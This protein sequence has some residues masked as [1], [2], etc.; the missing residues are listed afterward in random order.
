M[1]ANVASVETVRDIVLIV[2]K[3]MQK[4]E[5]FMWCIVSKNLLKA[6]EIMRIVL[7]IKVLRLRTFIF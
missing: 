2:K 6:R 1:A 7:I 4:S 5:N 3:D